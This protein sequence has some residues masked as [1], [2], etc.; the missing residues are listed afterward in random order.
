VLILLLLNLGQDLEVSW[1]LFEVLAPDCTQI[2]QFGVFG[3]VG[4]LKFYG[5]FL[6]VIFSFLTL[7]LDIITSALKIVLFAANLHNLSGSAIVILLQ[8]LKFTSLLKEGL[9]T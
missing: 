6:E 1:G 9:G 2:V 7:L 3:L 8:L 5:V 4:S